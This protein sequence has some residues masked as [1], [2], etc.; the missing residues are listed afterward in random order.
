MRLKESDLIATIKGIARMMY[1]VNIEVNAIRPALGRE[2]PI[3]I[4]IDL[5]RIR[6]LMQL[7]H[8]PNKSP[9]A[10]AFSLIRINSKARQ[11]PESMVQQQILFRTCLTPLC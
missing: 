10:I 5:P 11:I 1:L 8:V 2:R 6:K 9:L 4:T 3:A 7:K